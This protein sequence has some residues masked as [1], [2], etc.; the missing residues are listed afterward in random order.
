[1]WLRHHKLILISIDSSQ[2]QVDLRHLSNFFIS[3]ELWYFCELR[4][5][6]LFCDS[7]NLRIPRIS[8]NFHIPA[9][10]RE[11]PHPSVFLLISIFP[12][13]PWTFALLRISVN[14]RTRTYLILRS[15]S[16]LWTTVFM[17]SPAKLHVHAYFCNH[18]KNWMLILVLLC[19]NERQRWDASRYI[20]ARS[21]I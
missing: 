10:F 19:E 8:V 5:I 3:W 20:R 15:R 13:I 17:R 21:D 9:Y 2:P 7:L 14:F 18:F 11:F 12:C 16:F 6:T 1:M 4:I